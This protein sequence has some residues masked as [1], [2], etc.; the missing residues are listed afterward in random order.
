MR[1]R[2]AARPGFAAALT[3]L[4]AIAASP[5]AAQTCFVYADTVA[6]PAPL[7]CVQKAT[8]DPPCSYG[9]PDNN[10]QDCTTIPDAPGSQTIL[11]MHTRW[12]NCFGNRGG[13]NPPAGRGQRWYAFHRQF[14]HDFNQWRRTIG[15]DPI[16]SLHWCPGMNLPVGTG[17]ELDPGDH[18]VDCGQGQPR[19]T[20]STVLTASPS[21]RA[22][23]SKAA[24]PWAARRARAARRPTDRSASRTPTSSS[25]PTSTTSPRSST[26]SSTA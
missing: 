12:H 18:V 7:V 4:A 25:S 19:P 9:N 5:A 17:P 26:A 24:A 15:F 1:I 10:P 23:S 22:S 8:L 16:E 6:A 20:T 2:L 13:A 11:D 14:E 3:A 21:R